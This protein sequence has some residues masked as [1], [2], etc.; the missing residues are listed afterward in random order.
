[1]EEVLAEFDWQLA[2]RFGLYEAPQETE[3]VTVTR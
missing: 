2:E 3:M 1:M